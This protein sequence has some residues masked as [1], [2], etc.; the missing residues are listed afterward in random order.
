[1]TRR[2]PRRSIRLGTGRNLVVTLEDQFWAALHRIA[3]ERQIKT[4][5]IIMEIGADPN[6]ND[7]SISSAIRLYILTYRQAQVF[8]LAAANQMLEARAKAALEE[9]DMPWCE[10]CQCYHHTTAR[11]IDKSEQ[12]K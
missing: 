6:I 9:A 11:H 4:R 2:I 12:A 5:D 7:H 8:V 3:E 1:M 10:H